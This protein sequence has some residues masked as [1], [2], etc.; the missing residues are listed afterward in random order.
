MIISDGKARDLRR[1]HARVGRDARQ[2]AQLRRAA[3]DVRGAERGADLRDARLRAA[4]DGPA[5]RPHRPGARGRLL[6]VPVPR[7]RPGDRRLAGGR[8]RRSP[9][10]SSRCCRGPQGYRLSLPGVAG[11]IVAIGITADSF[12]VYFE[13]IRDELRDGRT[14]RR[15][16]RARAGRARAARSSRPTRSTSSPRS[17]CTCSPSA[18]CAGSRSPS[19]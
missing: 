5:R 15:R 10:A 13:R 17:C 16:R 18:G 6:A 7:A 19:A 14:L 3:A 12:I 8:R 1:L 11:L 9:T 4:R 2:P